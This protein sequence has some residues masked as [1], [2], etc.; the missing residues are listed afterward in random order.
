LNCITPV[1]K[2]DFVDNYIV[3]TGQFPLQTQ[4]SMHQL[5]AWKEEVCVGQTG[6]FKFSQM[7]R[8][9][10]SHLSTNWAV[11]VRY[12]ENRISQNRVAIFSTIPAT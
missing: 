3:K 8:V 6:I 10:K 5:L 7:V 12:F 4:I 11:P 9:K 2:N 1:W